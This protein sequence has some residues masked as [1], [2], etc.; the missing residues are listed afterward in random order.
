[1]HSKARCAGLVGLAMVWLS[2]GCGY[3]SVA[4][5][6]M[7]TTYAIE[8]SCPAAVPVEAIAGVLARVD[9]QMS[10]YR[11][12]SELM[13]FNRAPVGSWIDV[14]AD[15]VDVVAT[16]KAVAEHTGGAF[17]PTVGPL[18]AL[19]GFGASA[20]AGLP[21]E[22]AAGFPG[23]GE[24]QSTKALVDFRNLRHRRAPPALAKRRPLTLD[25]SAIAKGHAV[26]RIADV[27][28]A[29]AC[30]AYL[31]ELGGEL[32]AAGPSPSGGPWRVGVDSP[33]GHGLIGGPIVLRSG[34]VATSGD[35]RQ[36]R[37]QYRERDGQRLSHI[38]DPRTG[39]PARHRLASVTV[40]ADT[41]RLADAYATALMV[42]GE[43]EGLAF[44]N[45]T[46]LAARFV[47]RRN[48][49]FETVRSVAMSQH[50]S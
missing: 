24:V 4:G 36:Y 29:A 50:G 47:I 12:D 17:D 5:R 41:A 33:S 20:A 25:L 44:A 40:V 9:R 23:E 35:Y 15:L 48:E 10:T 34:G 3:E 7:G 42:L 27:L 8:A 37:G 30:V 49:G 26:D 22:A 28:D 2:A 46:G 14:S 16:A 13:V 19:W 1:M 21:G 32:R 45:Q 31:V 18:V 39:Y 6:T 11:P 43:R 38:I